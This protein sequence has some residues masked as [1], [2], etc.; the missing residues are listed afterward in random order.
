MTGVAR[1]RLAARQAGLLAHLI[2]DAPAPAG[3]DPGRLTVQA[4]VLRAK[5]ERIAR[6]ARD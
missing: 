3:F 6:R 1:A 4:A 5:H 2:A